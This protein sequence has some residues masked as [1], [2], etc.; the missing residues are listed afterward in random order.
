MLSILLCGNV[1]VRNRKGNAHIELEIIRPMSD[2][3]VFSRSVLDLVLVDL[4]A[5]GGISVFVEENW[6][7]SYA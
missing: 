5:P 6:V 4:V 2:A 3:F 1:W 7:A